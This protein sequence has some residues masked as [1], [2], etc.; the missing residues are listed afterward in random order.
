MAFSPEQQFAV[1]LG[2][3]LAK[4]RADTGWTQEAVAEHIGVWGDTIGRYERGSAL[5][6]L[7]RLFALSEL[8]GVSLAELLGR[9]STRT[10]DLALAVADRLARLKDEDRAWVAR[11]LDELCDRL[12]PPA[13]LSHQKK[14][15]R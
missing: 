3:A 10:E 2:Q 6:T 14:K 12:A 13:P 1:Q 5:P 7:Q 8:Y 4:A 11:W 15:H 9:S